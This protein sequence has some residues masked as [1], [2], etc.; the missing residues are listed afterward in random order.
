MLLSLILVLEIS[1]EEDT[2]CAGHE[3]QERGF[4]VCSQS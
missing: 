1:K 4:K 2:F 3:P